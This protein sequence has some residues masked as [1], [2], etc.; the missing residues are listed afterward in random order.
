MEFL[1]IPKDQVSVPY[2]S[3]KVSGRGGVRF[4]VGTMVPAKYTDIRG[5]E[6]PCILGEYFEEIA[7]VVMAGGYVAGS[8]SVGST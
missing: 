4:N 7:V 3:T 5:T 8:A 1:L 2:H 6:L